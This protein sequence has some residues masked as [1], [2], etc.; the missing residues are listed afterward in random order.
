MS[1]D[2]PRTKVRLKDARA[3]TASSQRWLSR[4][5]NDPYV[6]R[7]KSMG[8]RARS[9]FKLE[10]I[11]E[12]FGLIKRGRIVV[13]LGAAP[14]SWS[15]Y[16]VKKGA[17]VVAVDLQPMDPIA[18]VTIIEGDFLEAETEQAL[19]QV[20]EGQD[21]VDL[22]LS[23][24]AASS[25]GRKLV[26]RLRAEQLGEAVLTFAEAHVGQGGAVLIKLVRGAEA[27]LQQQAKT[28]FRSVRILRPEATR[29]DSSE[30]F[31]LALDR[32]PAEGTPAQEP[33]SLR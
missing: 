16:A 15:Q 6:Q 5:L 32:L 23:D 11:D 29:S 31:L 4:Q 25:T 33:G 10:E 19:V 27:V 21:R 7:A 28:I 2:G 24:M 26:D 22:V 20:L 14:G 3:H 18:G 30:C 1:G 8:Y 12:R 9:V 17:R 13:D